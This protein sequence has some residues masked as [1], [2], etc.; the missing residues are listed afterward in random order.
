[1]VCSWPGSSWLGTAICAETYAAYGIGNAA[2]AIYRAL[3]PISYE[4]GRFYDNEE[5][6]DVRFAYF[7][8][9]SQSPVIF[10]RQFFTD[11]PPIIV[12]AAAKPYGGYLGNTFERSW[13]VHS[14]AD[15][16]EIQATYKAKLVPLTM[17]EK[18]KLA[19]VA[20]GLGLDPGRWNPVTILH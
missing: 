19:V 9:V 11:I 8:K 15:G 1:M 13:G 6:S 14:S 18:L 16:E 4:L 10:G 3:D 17:S 12:A 2:Y 7:L 5:G 20:G